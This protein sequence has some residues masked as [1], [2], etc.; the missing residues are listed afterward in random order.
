M[1]I[2][3]PLT[4]NL[5][6]FINLLLTDLLLTTLENP[7][8]IKVF[9]NEVVV[10]NINSLNLIANNIRAFLLK[11]LHKCIECNFQSCSEN[12]QISKNISSISQIFLKGS[13]NQNYG[14]ISLILNF[15]LNLF[16]TLFTNVYK[17]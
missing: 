12:L 15:E 7:N 11:E 5:L 16:G 4:H 6:S 13:I 14:P 2:P 3:L 17:T 10:V 9:T 8:T 1:L